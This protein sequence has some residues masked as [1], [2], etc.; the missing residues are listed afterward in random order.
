M[1]IN[2]DTLKA[3][4]TTVS[5]A[6]IQHVIPAIIALTNPYN[7]PDKETLFPREID[8]QISAQLIPA[9]VST[10]LAKAKQYLPNVPE[11]ELRTAIEQ[12]VKRVISNSPRIQAAV[13]KD[14]T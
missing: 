5:P 12:S 14:K 2:N 10:K 4:T 8:L 11:A 6:E 9:I 7:D 1:G 3:V 13:Q